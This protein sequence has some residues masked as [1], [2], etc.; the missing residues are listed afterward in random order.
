[1][2]APPPP[3]QPLARRRLLAAMAVLV[4]APALWH[5]PL[6]LGMLP[7][8]MDTVTQIYPYRVAA[9]RQ[10]HAGTLPLWL[11]NQGGGMPLAANPQ[12]SVWYPPQLLFYLSPNPFGN[13][14]VL[15]FHYAWAGIGAFLF[16]RAA[17]A[18]NA[19]ALYGALSFQFGSMLVSRI[20]LTP[21]LYTAA[22]IPWMLLGIEH[23]LRAGG[24]RPNRG[25]AMVGAAAAMQVLA[26]SPQ[27]TY[28]TALAVAAYWIARAPRSLPSTLAQ[29]AAAGLLAFL[30]S[31]IQLLPAWE[32]AQAAERSSIAL[33]R[34]RGGALGGGFHWRALV[35]F[36]GPEI[37][38]TDSI[39]AVGL[40]ALLLVPLALCARSRRR[41][42]LPLVLVGAMGYL[43]S[44]GA[45]VGVWA[46]VLPLFDGFHAPRRALILWSVAGPLAMGLGA[47]RLG[48]LL[49]A[50]GA[51][52]WAFPAALCV[53][54]LG[55]AWILPRLEREFT[56]TERFQPPAEVVRIL[57][58]SRFA[59]VDPT[60][61][62]SYDS[63]RP[64][65]GASIMPDLASWFGLH[66]AQAYDPLVL[67]S[68][69]R[70]RDAAN[71]RGGL[72]FPSHGIFL[73]DIGSPVLRLLAVEY[74]I[75]RFDLFDPGR[76][77]PGAR[78]DAERA[79]GMLELVVDDE[80]WPLWRFRE[81]RPLAW[82]P[83]R[84]AAAPDPLA[85]WLAGGRLD[86]AATGDLRLALS[87]P[88]P[89]VSWEWR[90][91]RTL[92]IAFDAPLAEESLVCAAIPWID[93]WRARTDAAGAALVLPANGT[94]L[95]ALAPAGATE[96]VLR[97]SPASF[98]T[99]AM[100]SAAG[101]LLLLAL[102]LRRPA[103]AATA[104]PDPK[105]S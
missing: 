58:D 68:A 63:R 25:T 42:A 6:L 99:G 71:A 43:L 76:V 38:D 37:E 33:D 44:M 101:L 89:A 2:P 14:L 93:G 22:W 86:F 65:Y 8:F 28:Y 36:T 69:A 17:G 29:G 72:L 4:A 50:R 70:L 95:A 60:I 66:D 5:Y 54:F 52:R 48:A 74:I 26:G 57:G 27:I 59:T 41:I 47:A 75:G 46:R 55:T 7:D 9:A 62:Y 91:D 97:Y 102:G 18:R 103:K 53:L 84:V 94:H 98:W 51:P 105:D 77:I 34:I 79:A 12:V 3:T 40:G 87:A 10:I 56:T 96:L 31:A 82:I 81:P 35:G 11:P 21:H 85:A 80:R 90:D 39:N 15:L 23:A 32:F 24:W 100:L 45:L 88:P 49:R 67:Q 30:A 73:T 61:G 104:I 1:M 19:A 16:L 20:A 64:D 78:F 13:G 92:A 83:T